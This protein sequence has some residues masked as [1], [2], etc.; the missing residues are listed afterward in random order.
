M[1]N[2][3]EQL[4]HRKAIIILIV[5]TTI[6]A[7][8]DSITRILVQDYH[9]AQFI[10]IRQWV[11]L[12]FALWFCHHRVGL[13][14]AFK[15]GHLPL[16]IIRNI[17][18]ILELILFAMAIKVLQ[19]AE[20]HAIFALFPLIVTL[21]APLVLGET[22]GWRRLVAVMIGFVGA[23]II[24]RPGF[25]VFDEHALIALIATLF[26][27]FYQLLTRKVSR[28][29]RFE[30]NLLYLALISCIVATAWGLPN[31]QP[32]DNTSAWLIAFICGT[33]LL[34]HILLMKA[35]EY[36]PASVLQPFNYLTLVWAVILGYVIFNDLPD[37]Y[38]VI[39]SLI[40]VSSGLFVIMRERYLR[41]KRPLI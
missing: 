4:Q 2:I 36:A 8:Q 29:D 12:V 38:T 19:V 40:I 20:M 34:S 22:L 41:R 39:G 10:M 25:G 14:S 15:T 32:I 28:F 27:A 33:G 18:W 26:F 3:Q 6:F 9:P 35:L 13:K 37:L 23:L 17:C 7:L 11:F 16:Q 31:W 24:I 30:T 21:L 5:S 1:L